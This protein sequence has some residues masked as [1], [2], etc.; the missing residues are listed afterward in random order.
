MTAVAVFAGSSG[1]VPSRF[2]ETARELGRGIAAEG[3][4]VVY[5][6]AKV[7]TMGA[8][9]D[10]AL[11]AGGRVVGS[12]PRFMVDREVAHDGLAELAVCESMH[13][14]KAWMAERADAF[15]A[16]P[17][18]LGTFDELFEALTWRQIGLHAK[19]IVLVDLDG[20]F[21][22]LA[23]QIERA[24]ETAYMR[25]D[26]RRLLDM[27]PTPEAAIATIRRA[28]AEGPGAG[29]GAIETKWY[30]VTERG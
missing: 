3:W 11:A 9:A 23:A 2:L 20:Y 4:T 18:G 29:P 7:G 22:P 27:V 14:R 13:E 24:I 26:D 28:L 10:G 5:G 30:G 25:A 19:P 15:V 6:G 21:A 17:G 1:R 8:L 16:L 12:I